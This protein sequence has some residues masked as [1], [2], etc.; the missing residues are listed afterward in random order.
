V[1]TLPQ[2]A[3]QQHSTRVGVGAFTIRAGAWAWDSQ[4]K[5]GQGRPPLGDHNRLAGMG[6][7]IRREMGLRSSRHP[8][9]SASAGLFKLHGFGGGGRGGKKGR[10]RDL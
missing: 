2:G 6:A 9:S 7:S 4:D 10:R 3:E 1:C 8:A 5:H